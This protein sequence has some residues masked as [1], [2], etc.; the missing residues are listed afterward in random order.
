V[1]ED[2]GAHPGPLVLDVSV[3]AE[4]ARADA[5][6]M[7][8]IQGWDAAGQPLVIPAIAITGACLDVRSQDAEDLLHGLERLENAMVAP[9]RDTEQATRL[10]AIIA[11]TGLDPWDAHVAAVADASICPIATLDAAKWREHARD[12]DEPLYFVEIAD[13]E[14]KDVS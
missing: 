5:G 4:V 13:P 1:S 3:L 14:D 2:A 9:L 10:A 8:L 12:L 6:L 7:T 11:R